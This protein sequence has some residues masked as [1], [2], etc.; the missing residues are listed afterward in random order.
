MGW[1]VNATPRPLYPRER[2]RVPIVQEAG[3]AP[4]QVWTRAENL[5]P[6]GISFVRA[7]F[8]SFCSFYPLYS[9]PSY[10]L[11]ICYNIF[12]QHTTT[13]FMTPARFEP[14][15][16]ESSRPQTLALDRSATQIG[17][18]FDPGTVQSVASSYTDWAIPAHNINVCTTTICSASFVAMVAKHNFSHTGIRIEVED[19]PLNM[20]RSNNTAIGSRRVRSHKCKLDRGVNN[21]KRRNALAYQDGRW[22]DSRHIRGGNRQVSM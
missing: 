1:V 19:L 15:I 5:A 22:A 20:L 21:L 14:A 17:K 9:L 4:G 11:P 6:T 18:G 12:L 7:F 2:Y 16:P 13:T 3:W 8:L 10:P